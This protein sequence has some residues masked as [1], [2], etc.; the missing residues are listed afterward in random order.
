M[1]II[2]SRSS[3]SSRVGG[4]WCQ[5]P[6]RSTEQPQSLMSEVLLN[7]CDVRLC[8]HVMLMLRDTRLSM[9]DGTRLNL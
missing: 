8:K 4:G 3:K 9:N 1:Y 6:S 5:L 7:M 2:Y